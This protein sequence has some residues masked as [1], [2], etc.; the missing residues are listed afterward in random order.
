MAEA[1]NAPRISAK[2][3]GIVHING[4]SEI[5]CTVRNLSNTGAQLNFPHPTILPRVFHL[6]FDGNEQRVTVM[7]Q[8]GRLAGVRFQAPLRG[9]GA[10]KRKLWPW[11]RS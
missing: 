11:S 5:A 2:H 4:R 8:S 7:W 1:R 6:K 3:Q 9:I 10:V